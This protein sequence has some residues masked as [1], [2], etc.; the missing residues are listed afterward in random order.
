MITFIWWL[1]GVWKSTL[2][3]KIWSIDGFH[4]IDSDTVKFDLESDTDKY[5]RM[6]VQILPDEIRP[7]SWDELIERGSRWEYDRYISLM[8]FN[9]AIKQAL[10]NQGQWI[11]TVMSGGFLTREWREYI[12]SDLRRT[13]NLG[14]W[15]IHLQWDIDDLIVVARDRAL[16]NTNSERPQA[17]E[18]D[19]RRAQMKE[20]KPLVQEWWE[21]VISIQR[22]EVRKNVWEIPELQFL[23]Q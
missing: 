21:R 11:K 6:L 17:W 15:F 2:W 10:D 22:E 18:E 5:L 23:F 4:H 20:E 3:D 12:V 16:H 1:Q 8:C 7:V 19:V 9:E 13:H 14:A